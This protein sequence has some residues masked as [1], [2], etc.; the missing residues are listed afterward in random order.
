[1]P[2][3]FKPFPRPSA[4]H[5]K[6]WLHIAFSDDSGHVEKLEL[7]QTAF[8]MDPSQTEREH[9]YEIDELLT[10][11]QLVAIT[12]FLK[13]LHSKYHEVG[14]AHVKKQCEKSGKVFSLLQCAASIHYQFKQ[15]Y[16]K[17][18]PPAQPAE[19]VQPT[20][21]IVAKPLTPPKPILK[22]PTPLQKYSLA[23]EFADDTPP[24]L[25]LLREVSIESSDEKRKTSFRYHFA[26]LSNYA[27]SLLDANGRLKEFE[28]LFDAIKKH[29]NER[30]DLNMNLRPKERYATLKRYAIEDIK[31]LI[32][33][34]A[35]GK[36]T[37]RYVWREMQT[38][39]KKGRTQV[40]H[41]LVL[42]ANADTAYD[43]FF[44]HAFQP[45]RNSKRQICYY[46]RYIALDPMQEALLYLLKGQSG[47]NEEIAKN[48]ITPSTAAEFNAL[49]VRIAEA[50]YTFSY[51]AD[52]VGATSTTVSTSSHSTFSIARKGSGS[53]VH[54]SSDGPCTP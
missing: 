17:P 14:L 22:R 36:K 23:L 38:I 34:M 13:G 40:T 18:S 1:M 49:L 19:P 54:F 35:Q 37:K 26:H 3:L 48:A 29:L 20:P 6:N 33:D 9:F 30:V 31:Q 27:L 21:A 24:L 11:E 7:V 43:N 52:R 15:R 46:E 28:A 25:N 16:L 50:Q 39:N 8:G 12:K 42:R 47:I 5:E 2:K 41:Q 45:V 32:C 51:P 53:S 4:S 44:D 10:E